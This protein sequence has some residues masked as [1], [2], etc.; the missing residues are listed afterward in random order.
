MRGFTL[1]ELLLVITAAVLVA[2]FTIPTGIRFFQIQLLDEATSDILGVV[3]RAQS[4]AVFQKN[5]SVFGVRFLPSSYVLFQGSSYA[6]RVQSEDETFSLGGGIT[7]TGVDE[8]VFGK[9]T[10][11]PNATSTITI[12]SGSDMQTLD[13]NSQGKIERQ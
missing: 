5:D 12:T 2:A 7:A 1:L 4:Q 9:L 3:R 10:G 11:L 13:I 8:V 6:L